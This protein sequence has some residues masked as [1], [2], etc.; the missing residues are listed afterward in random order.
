M[1]EYQ[2]RRQVVAPLTP[3]PENLYMLATVRMSAQRRRQHTF[4]LDATSPL[5]TESPLVM[6]RGDEVATVQRMLTDLQTSTVILAGDPGAGKSLLAALLYRRFQLSVQ[7]GLPAPKHFAWLRLGDHI[8]LPDVIAA[9]LGAINVYVPGIFFQSPEQQIATL[10]SA[11][12]RPPEPALVVLD[13]CEKLFYPENPTDAQARGALPLFQ[14]MLQQE[15]GASRVLLTCYRSPFD[16]QET[17]VSRVRSFLLSRISLPEGVAYLQQ[18]GV[19]GSYEALSLVW[20]RCNGHI[21]SLVLFSALSRLSGYALSY[22]L[23]APDYQPLWSGEVV[24]NL[25]S[26]V[27]HFLSPAQ[28]ALIQMLALFTEPAPARGLYTALIGE[29]TTANLP[30]FEQELARLVNL[31]LLQIIVNNEGETCYVLPSLWRDYV[32]EHYLEGSRRNSGGASLGVSSPLSPAS[33]SAEARD[34]AVA[35]GHMRI[36][37]YYRRRAQEECAPQDERTGPQDMQHTLSTIRHLSLGWQWQQAWDMLL[38][39]NVY[40]RMVQWGAW[41]TLIGLYLNILPPNGV[42]TRRDEGL[43]CNHLGLVFDRLGNH[44]QSYAY[45]ERALVV[46]RQV[47]DRHGAAM[48]LTNEGELL[49]SQGQLP[50]AHAN[51]EQARALNAALHDSLL[52]SVL[53]QNL[54]LLYHAIKDYPRA[55]HFYQE[56]L[57]FAKSLEEPYN[58]GMILTNIG[59]LWYEQ[60]YYPESLALLQAVLQDRRSLQFATVDYIEGFLDTLEQ[61]LGSEGFAQLRQAARAVKRDVLARLQLA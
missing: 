41:N 58:K 8:T 56:A 14:Q 59:V 4:G 54:G 40:E 33:N 43:I 13:Q 51:F 6:Q 31:S 60:G 47:G 45:Y 7:A 1:P 19:K 16:Q 55:L 18:S 2:E 50:L 5:P 48:T 9:I 24:L 46:Q 39:E 35:A 30:L 17:D 36:A 53:L 37:A 21:F 38:S 11:L 15:L 26:A 34:I 57:R 27:Y 23:D 29:D 3:M 28:H 25:L 20:Q 44:R 22:L 10:L 61:R 49:R 32:L 12:R 52:E 42:I